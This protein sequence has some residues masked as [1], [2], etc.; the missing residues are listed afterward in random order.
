MSLIINEL[1][2]NNDLSALIHERCGTHVI[3]IVVQCGL[4]FLEDGY[5]KVRFFCLKVYLII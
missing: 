4:E 3:N 2:T 5:D 1:K